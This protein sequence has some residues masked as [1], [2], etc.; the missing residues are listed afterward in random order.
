MFPKKLL[1]YSEN[2]LGA[3]ASLTLPVL[4]SIWCGASEDDGD[5]CEGNAMANSIIFTL[6][7]DMYTRTILSSPSST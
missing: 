2:M 4:E 6:R 1:C 5:I 7:K 3:R